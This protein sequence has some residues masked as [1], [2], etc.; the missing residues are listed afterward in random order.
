MRP[1]FLMILTA[2]ALIAGSACSLVFAA[3]STDLSKAQSGTY[4]LDKEHANILFNLSH[5]GFSHYFGRFNSMD[6]TLTFD[7]KAPENSKV[8]ISVDVGS[9]DTNNAKL[10]G[11]LKSSQWFD[12]PQ[13]P[14]ATFSSTRIEKLSETTGKVYGDLTLHGVTK[15][16]V[17][18][19]TFNGAGTNP[20]AMDKVMLGFSGQ[21]SIKRS[22]FGISQYIP[23]V[24]DEVTLTIE[25]E[26]S[27]QK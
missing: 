3:P 2:T 11:E 25:A 1:R 6:G 26:F 7:A 17:L 24:G 9:I 22:E 18:D 27:L 20:V 5:L 10:E 15:P 13:F 19:V 16:I 8:N 23:M 4:M 21:T 14:N 12:T